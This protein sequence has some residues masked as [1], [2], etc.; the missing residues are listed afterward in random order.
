MEL[1]YFYLS[2]VFLDSPSLHTNS[3]TE[4]TIPCW[5]HTWAQMLLNIKIIFGHITSEQII[6]LLLNL[7][8]ISPW[9]M[10][11][12]TS[13]SQQNE[14]KIQP[15]TAGRSAN[16]FLPFL[17]NVCFRFSTAEGFYTIRLSRQRSAREERLWCSA[18]SAG[19]GSNTFWRSVNNFI[20]LSRALALTPNDDNLNTTVNCSRLSNLNTASNFAFNPAVMVIMKIRHGKYLAHHL[21]HFLKGRPRWFPNTYISNIANIQF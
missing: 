5:K 17:Q 21:F 20:C 9:C 15:S 6:S 4:D 2:L 18:E 8:I 1:F 13:N 14:V 12:Y 11:L 7:T 19:V 16:C 10:R 3:Y